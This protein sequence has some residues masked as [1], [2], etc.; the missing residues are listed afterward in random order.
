M[1]EHKAITIYG[2][3]P[4]NSYCIAQMYEHATLIRSEEVAR[5]VMNFYKQMNLYRKS[6]Y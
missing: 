6:E 4:S 2:N 5:Y 1:I 3:V